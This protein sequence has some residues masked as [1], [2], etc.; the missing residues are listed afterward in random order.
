MKAD[1]CSKKLYGY[2]SWTISKNEK[3][4]NETF[5]SAIQAYW[6]LSGL[7]NWVILRRR[8]KRL[9]QHGEKQRETEN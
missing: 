8:E 1:I 7:I 6:R 3:K 5:N 2:E 9:A 4:N